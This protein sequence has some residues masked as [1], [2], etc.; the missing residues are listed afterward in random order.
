MET[1]EQI[2]AKIVADWIDHQDITAQ[3]W[4]DLRS[5]IAEALTQ[6]RKAPKG[7]VVDEEGNVWLVQSVRDFALLDV[8]SDHRHQYCSMRVSTV[9]RLADRDDHQQ[10]RITQGESPCRMNR[11]PA[12][13][14]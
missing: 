12:E 11:H 7:C 2:A 13:C 6:A 14:K 1:A 8:H 4:Q 5:S 3:E 9:A 10:Q